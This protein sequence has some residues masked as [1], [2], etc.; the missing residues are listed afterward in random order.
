MLDRKLI[1]AYLTLGFFLLSLGAPN[2][3]A[4]QSASF[5]AVMVYAS[6]DTAKPDPKV[7]GIANKLKNV[8]KFKHYKSA[9]GG[10]A[11]I[12]VPGEG[13]INLGSGFSL[14][15]KAKGAEKGRI[16]AQVLWKKGG[17]T[18]INTQVVMSKNNP[19]VIGGHSHQSGKMIVT[20]TLK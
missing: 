19:A 12:K 15:V 13:T 8:F 14:V 2:A 20:L 11:T 6:N 3:S 16:R 7:A 4:Q 5:R 1:F 9:G 18:L 17:T 10:N